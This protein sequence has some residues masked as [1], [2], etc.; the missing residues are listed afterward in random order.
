MNELHLFAGAGGG[1]LGGML[2]GH[3][4][5]CAVEIEPYC[6]KVLL[7]R[8]RDGI[9][10]KFPIWDDVRTF[11]GK[12]WRGKVDIVCG[13]FP[14][15]DI[16]CAG[17]GAGIGGARSGLWSEFARI[18]SEVR[19]RYVFV[20]N[21]PMLAVRGLGRVL[22]DLSEIG[23]D[24]RWCVMGAD[25]VGA[26][27]T[28]KRMWILAHSRR[29]SG[30]G[31]FGRESR[32]LRRG[33]AEEVGERDSNKAVRPSEISNAVA[34][35]NEVRKLQSQGI[36]EKFGRRTCYGG[37]NMAN[38][39]KKR[40]QGTRSKFETTGITR[41]SEKV[42][43]YPKMPRQP[44]GLNRQA[45]VQFGRSCT[46]WD[47]DP[48]D[49]DGAFES[50]LGRVADGVANRVDRLKAIGNGQVPLVAATA[51]KLLKGDGD[52]R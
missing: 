37:E 45:Q 46:W 41:N 16:S 15:Q 4:C 11:D 50:Q 33:Q 18:V 47:R 6:R 24:A 10:P 5:V 26:P 44:S 17:K 38:S 51:F 31:D 25:D 43:S 19:P 1:I 14:C 9:L 23:Y 13:G 8:Q 52:E 22:G 49:Q 48:A 35:A 28:R 32:R 12:P 29:G 3:T 30:R 42:L 7:Q 40:L 2:L 20:E 34:D 21:S 39:D 36:V 27:H